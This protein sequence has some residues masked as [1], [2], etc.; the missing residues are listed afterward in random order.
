M[1]RHI[2]GPAGQ[3]FYRDHVTLASR[4]LVIYRDTT[5]EVAQPANLCAMVALS[6][7]RNAL[8]AVGR[9]F[10][11]L[12]PKYKPGTILDAISSLNINPLIRRLDSIFI[13]SDEERRAVASLPM[14]AADLRTDQDIVCERDSPSRC[15]VML[16]G[17]ACSY[18]V[19]V[20]GKRQI[21]A[22]HNVGRHSRPS[23][24]SPQGAGQQRG[25]DHAI[26]SWV[27]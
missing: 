25:H 21:L 19:T 27:H 4:L 11:V 15:C 10:V 24:S 23:E 5:N 22:F 13:L 2:R 14:Q 6:P 16:D 3:G 17:F 18:K 12:P 20:A 1:D 7:A 26:Q 9:E 8:G